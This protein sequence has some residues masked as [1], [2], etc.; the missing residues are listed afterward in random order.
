MPNATANPATPTRRR[1]RPR[2]GE[3]RIKVTN[4]NGTNEVTFED[5]ESGGRNKRPWHELYE[6]AAVY[7]DGVL[8]AFV[9]NFGDREE[10]FAKKV[11][12]L[13]IPLER[14]SEHPD[15]RAV[16]LL[17][18]RCDMRKLKVHAAIRNGKP[19]LIVG[20]RKVVKRTRK[21]KDTETANA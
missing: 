1:G 14:D 8:N 18:D 10:G 16:R 2:K 7:V 19:H 9:E 15:N 4:G 3:L 6:N 20:K 21:P 17:N 11:S 5:P 13:N 12:G